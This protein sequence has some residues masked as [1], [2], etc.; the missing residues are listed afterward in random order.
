MAAWAED[1]A[2][3]SLLRH[4]NLNY[5]GRYRFRASP[6]PHEGLRP[7]GN[8]D[9]VDLDGRWGRRGGVGRAWRP[10]PSAV[11]A[12]P[13]N[14]VS[15]ELRGSINAESVWSAMRTGAKVVASTG[16]SPVPGFRA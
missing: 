2:R 12:G 7:L 13:E 10:G 1:A 4:A 16:G 9:A 6:L 14:H 11:S 15:P 3:L 5:V 8:P